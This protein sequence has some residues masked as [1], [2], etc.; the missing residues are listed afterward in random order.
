VQTHHEK[1]KH[2]KGQNQGGTPTATERVR[3]CHQSPSSRHPNGGLTTI[4]PPAKI[5]CD[6]S[7]E[8]KA[9]ASGID[10]LVLAIDITWNEPNI[11]MYLEELK[12]KAKA[13]NEDCA[14]TINIPGAGEWPFLV[15]PY[16]TNGYEWLLTGNC[17]TLSVGNWL[18]PISRPSVIAEIRS[19][20]LW[21]LSPLGTI[22]VL[23]ALLESAGARLILMKPSRVDLCVDLLMPIE[24]WM[25]ELMDYRVTGA[26]DA[27]TYYHNKDMTGLGIGRG[28]I[29]ARLYD[30]PLE[31]RQKSK[32]FWM[33]DKWGG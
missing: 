14:G 9:L 17:F 26:K 7:G 2:T 30:K 21:E 23:R 5:S 29:S 32:K 10:T 8:F 3:D 24:V 31:I 18:K 12:E 4:S 22:A 1:T 20:A 33:F 16:G 11:F 19:Q 13:S 28:K 15:K 6:D 27:S 25:P